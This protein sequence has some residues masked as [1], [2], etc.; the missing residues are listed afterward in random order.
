MTFAG[1]LASGAAI[2][3]GAEAR[4][5]IWSGHATLLPVAMP[6]WNEQ[7]KIKSMVV[8]LYCYFYSS[9]SRVKVQPPPFWFPPACL[10]M[11]T[12]LLDEGRQWL[13]GACSEAYQVLPCSLLV[14]FLVGENISLV[15]ILRPFLSL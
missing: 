15:E 13:C 3:A 12:Q 14:V 1:E 6:V 8:L 7:D 11:S 2:T 10:N 5:H 4:T 9:S